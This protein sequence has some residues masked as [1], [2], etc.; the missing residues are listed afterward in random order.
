MPMEITFALMLCVSS[1][2]GFH[3]PAGG[4]GAAEHALRCDEYR[5]ALKSGFINVLNRV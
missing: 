5:G 3:S 1:K 4:P 2:H